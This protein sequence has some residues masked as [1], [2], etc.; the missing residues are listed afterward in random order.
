MEDN[1]LKLKS[2]KV[3]RKDHLRIHRRI[4]A[5]LERDE[6]TI[7]QADVISSALDA[8]DMTERETGEVK[9]RTQ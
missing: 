6:T 9:S 5:V 8:L 3:Y 1:L 2:A 7:T 4:L